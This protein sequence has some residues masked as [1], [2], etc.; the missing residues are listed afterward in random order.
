[1][2]ERLLRGSDSERQKFL[3]DIRSEMLNLIGD[4]FDL[5]EILLFSRL[6][7]RIKDNGEIGVDKYLLRKLLDYDT[8]EELFSKKQEI[9]DFKE[10]YNSLKKDK[11]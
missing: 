8:N 3:E 9:F 4:I 5:D 1:M 2:E 7:K 11:E 10:L 6:P